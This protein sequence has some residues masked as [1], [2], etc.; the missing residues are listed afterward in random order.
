MTTKDC[1]YDSRRILRSLLIIIWGIALF[2][3]MMFSIMF[4]S[5]CSHDPAGST[6]TSVSGYTMAVKA[7]PGEVLANGSDTALITVEVWDSNGNYVD[8]ETVTFSSTLGSL[9]NDT[10][11]TSNGVA[12]NTFTSSTSDGMAIVA[13]AVENIVAKV[14]IVQF[15]TK[16]AN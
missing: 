15:Y 11:T 5:G 13:A 9:K 12:I 1:K 16:G 4:M 2:A 10:L 8:G 14:E 7:N 3:G 6:G